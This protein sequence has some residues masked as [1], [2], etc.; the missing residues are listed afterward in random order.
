MAHHYITSVWIR[1]ELT[2]T[3]KL[4]SPSLPII[5]HNLKDWIHPLHQTPKQKLPDECKCVSH[6]TSPFPVFSNMHSCVHFKVSKTR[7]AYLPVPSSICPFLYLEVLKVSAETSFLY[8][9]R[10]NAKAEWVYRVTPQLQ[11]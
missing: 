8:H 11:M 10:K 7:A 6:N 2:T 4:Q 9:C 5:H 1:N 3:N